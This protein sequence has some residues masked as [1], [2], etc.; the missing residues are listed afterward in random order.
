MQIKSLSRFR[1]WPP[2]VLRLEG[3]VVCLLRAVPWNIL[4]LV[5]K[6]SPCSTVPA[7]HVPTG[8]TAPASCPLPSPGS[9]TA[10]GWLPPDWPGEPL[11]SPSPQTCMGQAVPEPRG[12]LINQP[13][14]DSQ[15][16]DR[17]LSQGRYPQPCVGE[18]QHF[19]TARLLTEWR[20][21][22]QRTRGGN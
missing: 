5:T 13:A 8:T 22:K 21:K 15:P 6:P 9:G 2:M 17:V 14:L 20:E 19:N 10:E 11:P 16:S 3:E 1:P 12:I 4:P 7:S 18:T